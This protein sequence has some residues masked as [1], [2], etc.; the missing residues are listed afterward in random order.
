VCVRGESL[1]DRPRRTRYVKYIIKKNLPKRE[2]N[3]KTITE[4]IVVRRTTYVGSPYCATCRRGG[5]WVDLVS[6]H[7]HAGWRAAYSTLVRIIIIIIIIITIVYHDNRRAGRRRRRRL[8]SQSPRVSSAA[9]SRLV[10][11]R[12]V[13]LS[14]FSFSVTLS[15]SVRARARVSV[16]VCWCVCSYFDIVIIV[17]FAC[18]RRSTENNIAITRDMLCVAGNDH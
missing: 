10:C 11:G 1:T 13:S 7:A 12:T 16:C 3:E 14:L 8:E 2:R 9:H 17:G 5:A 15:S 18:Q 4:R 6:F